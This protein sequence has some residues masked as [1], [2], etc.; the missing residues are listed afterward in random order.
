M[1]LQFLFYSGGLHILTFSV[2]YMHT[3]SYYGECCLLCWFLCIMVINSSFGKAHSQYYVFLWWFLC[4]I[5]INKVHSRWSQV[6]RTGQAH[7]LT[8][9]ILSQIL[10]CIHHFALFA[11]LTN[12]YC[13]HSTEDKQH[14]IL[15][16]LSII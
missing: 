2:G 1:I 4:I 13:E 3:S 12:S 16:Q 8:W 11:P 7:R 9:F 10:H 14:H 5:V 6:L 15:K